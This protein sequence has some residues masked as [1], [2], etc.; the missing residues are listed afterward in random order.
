MTWTVGYPAPPGVVAPQPEY[1]LPLFGAVTDTL[2]DFVVVPPEPVQAS[3]YDVVELGATL[4]LP[5][6]DIVPD[7]PP[8]ARQLVAPLVDQPS[9][10]RSPAVMFVGLAVRETVGAA[11][12]TD[13]IT[14]SEAL[15]PAPAH[16]IAY[17]D[18]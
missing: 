1:P 7:Q 3:V 11:A 8:D 2:T 5:A 14:E 15:P 12:V 18:V 17:V 9:V 13:T 10:E 4:A 16:V 6:V